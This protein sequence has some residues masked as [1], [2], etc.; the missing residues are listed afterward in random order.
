[1]NKSLVNLQQINFNKIKLKN[2]LKLTN[3]Y[4]IIP[5]QYHNEDLIFQTPKMNLPF[6]LTI[7]NEQHYLK[8]SFLN[9]ENDPQL[10]IFRNF[11]N[12][13][14]NYLE[15]HMFSELNINSYYFL[16]PLGKHQ[17]FPD[18]LS[19]KIFNNCP[20]NL[21][22]FD[23]YKNNLEL[24]QIQKSDY[25][26]SIIYISNIW[27]NHE[28]HKWGYDIYSLQ[29]KIY[30]IYRHLTEYSFIDDLED[31]RLLNSKFH[32]Q[33]E[34]TKKVNLIHDET[35][36]DLVEIKFHSRYQKYFK[37]LS[38]GVPKANI[39]S[40]MNI[41]GFDSDLIDYQPE[42]LISKS[43]GMKKSFSGNVDIQQLLENK[44]KLKKTDIRRTEGNTK[45]KN[46]KSFFSLE[47][48]LKRIKN[49]KKTNITL[50]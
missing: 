29:L 39:R 20:E 11:L 17:H 15:K 41:D 18:L 40:Q 14:G 13:F 8:L 50:I 5:I 34:N 19:T 42:Y 22:I 35:S 48:L 24:E 1:M 16:N 26:K 49:L 2:K 32:S 31:Q 23:Q 12:K 46:Q 25:C 10:L 45:K 37:M 27:I 36:S 33:F 47:D 21:L 30:T 7:Y 4:T 38:V 44:S 9:S 6:G 43:H 28:F 3:K